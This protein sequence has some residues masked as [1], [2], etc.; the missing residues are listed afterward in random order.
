MRLQH[1][2]CFASVP[3]LKGDHVESDGFGHSKHQRQQPD[4]HD[5]HHRHRG[6]TCA[7]Y[8]GPGRHCSVP[9]FKDYCCYFMVIYPPLDHT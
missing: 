1:A 2:G 5:L 7:L 6:D 3:V 4:E 9:G 8:P